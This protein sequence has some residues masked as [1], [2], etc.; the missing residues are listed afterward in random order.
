VTEI[1]S[2]IGA[3]TVMATRLAFAPETLAL[4]DPVLEVMREAFTNRLFMGL[5]VLVVAGI[6]VY[7]VAKVHKAKVKDTVRTGTIMVVL[8]VTAMLAAGWATLIAPKIDQAVTGSL[9]VVGQL[10]AHPHDPGA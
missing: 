9:A 5:F 2:T 10:V 3:F 7:L 6:C 8:G 4:L 1:A